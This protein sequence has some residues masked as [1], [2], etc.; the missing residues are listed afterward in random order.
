MIVWLRRLGLQK[1]IFIYVGAGL[2]ALMTLLTVFSLQTINEG[3]D[4]VRQERVSQAENMASDIDEII[5]HL[6]TEIVGTALVLGRTWQDDL[7][8]SHKE[9]LASLQRH[10]QE[11]LVTFYQMEQGF[12][13]TVVDTRGKV[14]WTEPYLADKVN[15]SLDDT[16]VVRE[17]VEKGQVYI[18]VEEALL[19]QDSP[20]L[21]PVVPI[22][23]DRG[24]V[25]GVLIVD[26]PAFTSNLRSNLVHRW[27]TDYDWE[28]LS[29]SGSILASSVS[30][31]VMEESAHWENI[32]HL[33]QEQQS[34][35]DVH[36]GSGETGTH[37]IAFAP[38]MQVPWG[39]TLEQ[40]ELNVFGIPWIMGRRLL[41]LT[42]LA[43]LVAIGLTW[44]VTRQIVIPLQRLAAIAQQFGTGDL[45]VQVP[46]MGQDEI[47][48][49]AQSLDTMRGQLKYSLEEIRQWNEQLE[50]RVKQR[51]KELEELYHKLRE[52]DADRSN[53]LGKIITAQ[54]EERRR[55]ARE[56]HDEV[57]QTLTGLVM[58]LG[59]V[60]T[61]FARGS[62]ARQRLESLRRLTSDA[63]EEI[64]RLIHDLRPS[65]LDDLGLVPAIS[66]YVENYLTPAG[67]KAELETQSFDHRLPPT[68]EITLFRVVQEA[69]TNIV[70]H[71]QAK[72]ARIRLQLTGYTIIGSIED[73]G[74]GFDVPSLRR[75]RHKGLG[76]G[77]VG[78]EE[79]ISLLGGEL[80]IES[81]IGGGT[82]ITF[83]IPL[84]ERSYEENSHSHS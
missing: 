11:Y 34:G 28:L 82:R 20:T 64:R 74:M 58:S 67:V 72:T 5:E 15:Q 45:E 75:E 65:L 46:A 68:V 43:A 83:E 35:I 23:D 80:N 7:T 39:V 29:A 57:S 77:L 19:T 17:V 54:E 31:Q 73:N 56:L 78:M 52:R 76:V 38:L 81:R 9:E 26:M 16:V 32:R 21:S 61:Q 13:I 70:K 30:G 48:R 33:A 66:W 6:R 50:Q 27:T 49:L 60:E 8:D 71:A 12:F 14:L 47:G 40:P 4:L 24:M 63:V 10:L 79:R 55:I 36:P 37:L 22:Q 62:E 44:I 69:I 3:I 42:G 2:L 18:E 53:L 25:R 51:T 59:S 84:P 41:M 1:K